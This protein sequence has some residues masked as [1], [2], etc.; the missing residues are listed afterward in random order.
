[1]TL[2]KNMFSIYLNL[3]NNIKS[4]YGIS[5]VIYYLIFYVFLSSKENFSITEKDLFLR[6]YF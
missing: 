1:M 5:N 3:T 6:G 4:I 2:S